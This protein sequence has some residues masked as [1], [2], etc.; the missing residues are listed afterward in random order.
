MKKYNK[1][2]ETKTKSLRCRV[3]HYHGRRHIATTF[4]CPPHH[5]EIIKTSRKITARL[6]NTNLYVSDRIKWIY[7]LAGLF[8]LYR[9]LS[10]TT[11]YKYCYYYYYR[12]PNISINKKILLRR[13]RRR[14]VSGG[15]G[16]GYDCDCVA[17]LTVE[18]V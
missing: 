9:I 13:W 15:G 6:I 1:I 5:E 3:C 4:R 14:Y 8:F 10:I 11:I 16:C 18:R 17:S 12:K 2:S 7:F